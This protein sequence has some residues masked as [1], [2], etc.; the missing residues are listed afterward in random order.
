MAY[1]VIN[2]PEGQG[3]QAKAYTG[4]GSADHAITLDGTTDMQPDWVWIKNRENETSDDP[5]IWFDVIRGVT[6]YIATTSSAA[7]ATDADTLDAF[8]S[9]GFKVDADT[10]VNTN[11]ETYVAWCWKA[12]GSGSS[13]ADGAISTTRSLN[14]DAGISIMKYTGSGSGSNIAHGLGATPELTIRKNIT[15]DEDWYVHT[16]IIDGS[17]D[18]MKLNTT[19]AKA[20][21]GLTA[22]SSTLVYTAADSATHI[23]YALKSVQGFSKFISYVGNSSADGKFLY[24]GFKPAFV[25]TKRTDTTS[26]WYIWDNKRNGYNGSNNAL[27]AYHPSVENTTQRIDL[28]SNGFKF[29]HADSDHNGSSG[30]YIFMAFAE[31]P[32]V[33]SKGVPCNA[34]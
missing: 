23:V 11:A 28:L 20:D 22:A 3:F 10:K 7:E 18:Y 29:R 19:A 33:N 16:T 9:D 30:T 26:A 5:H 34:R 4:N 17:H 32:F 12:G 8:Q 6:K 1:T 21:S 2:D 13:N 15:G 31:A 27:F 14:A 24:C 25:M